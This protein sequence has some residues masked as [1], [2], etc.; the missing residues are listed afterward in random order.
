MTDTR[1]KSLPFMNSGDHLENIGNM[2]EEMEID[3]RRNI[4]GMSSSQIFFFDCFS[5]CCGTCR[6]IKQNVWRQYFF[7]LSRIMWSLVVVGTRLCV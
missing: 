6:I 4:D 3:L 2:I 1:E 7:I 5:I